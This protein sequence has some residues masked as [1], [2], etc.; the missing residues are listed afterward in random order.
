[1]KIAESH[2]EGGAR[3]ERKIPREGKYNRKKNF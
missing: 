2:M 3:D 1:M